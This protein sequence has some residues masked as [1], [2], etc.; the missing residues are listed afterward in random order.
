[1]NE[2]YLSLFNEINSKT[3]RKRMQMIYNAAGNSQK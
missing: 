2:Y 1:M 3:N